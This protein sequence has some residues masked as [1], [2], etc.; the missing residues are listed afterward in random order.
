MGTLYFLS[1]KSVKIINIEDNI[2]CLELFT[3]FD[4][5]VLKQGDRV[6]INL[7]DN[8]HEVI[9]KDITNDKVY[10]K[11]PDLLKDVDNNCKANIGDKGVIQGQIVDDFHLLDKNAIFTI[12]TASVQEID[13]QLQAFGQSA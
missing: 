6:E 10:F 9:L 1:L 4:E 7:N 13:R 3:P 8:K 11:I 12:T 5:L 2:I